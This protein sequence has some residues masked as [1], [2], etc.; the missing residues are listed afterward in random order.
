MQLSEK[1][2]Q[3][4]QEKIKAQ[5]QAM[6]SGKQSTSEDTE[7]EADATDQDV[8]P[9]G[10]T[11]ERPTDA[12][13][14][15]SSDVQ[16]HSLSMAADTP[17]SPETANEEKDLNSS[18]VQSV[19]DSEGGAPAGTTTQDAGDMQK[20]ETEAS[21]SE[22]EA[23]PIVENSEAQEEEAAQATEGERVFWETM[24]QEGGSNILTW[25]IVFAVIGVAIV[26]VGVG[27]YLGFLFAG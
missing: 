27:V 8:S 2:K 9:S 5:R 26:L 12:V 7:E 16:S 15:L 13:D 4:L 24:E 25:K 14:A 3:A 20:T 18:S 19:V 6:W 11:T 23:P 10:D 21:T 17:A 1:D 22:A